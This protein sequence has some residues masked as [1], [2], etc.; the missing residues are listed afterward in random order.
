[1]S[2]FNWNLVW[3]LTQFFVTHWLYSVQLGFQR[4]QRHTLLQF[5]V[6]WWLVRIANVYDF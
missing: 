6:A 5:L 2:K 1:M 3:F 4:W